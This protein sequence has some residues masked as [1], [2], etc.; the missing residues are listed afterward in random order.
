M[1]ERLRVFVGANELNYSE[2][3][4]T[5]S[6]D[7]QV[8]N[9]T[10][11]IEANS[12]VLDS[13]VI[14]F[15]KNDGLTSVMNA[16]VRSLTQEQLWKLECFT[17][18]YEL[19]NVWVQQVY[20]STSPEGIIADVVNNHTQNLTY[21]GTATSG[22]TLTG[23]I[24]DAY[25][26]DVIKDMLFIL[27]WQLRIDQN[28]NVYPEPQGTV[29]NGKTFTNG[30]NI[31]LSEW[32]SDQKQMFN[33]VRIRGGFESYGE[34][35]SLTGSSDTWVLAHKPSGSVKATVGGTV[36]D[37]SLYTVDAENK[38]I[39]FTSSRTD[40]VFDYS[41][42]R[43]IIVDDQNDSSISTYGEIFQKFEAPWLNSAYV[44]RKYAAGLLDAFSTPPV[45]AK[46][47]APNLDFITD[48]GEL[49]TLADPVRSKSNVQAVVNK[50]TL[51]P[52]QNITEYEF[53]PRD[54]L[55]SDW[56]ADVQNRIKQIERRISD[57][58]QIAFSRIFKHDMKVTLSLDY[59]WEYNTPGNS[60]VVGHP[61]L[62]V[63]RKDFDTEPDC[64]TNYNEGVWTGANVDG[65]GGQY[66]SSG[67]RLSCGEFNGSDTKVTVADDASMLNLWDGGGTIFM[68]INP[69]AA[70]GRTLAMKNRWKLWIDDEDTGTARIYFRIY[71]SGAYGEWRTSP[72]RPLT[73]GSWQSISVTYNSSDLTTPPVI[74]I[75]DV[76]QAIT[77]VNIPNG[78]RTTDSGYALRLGNY[79]TDYYDGLMDEV[80]M[81]DVA[82]DDD[83]LT[84][85]HNKIY[86]LNDCVLYFAFD[87]PV[88]GDHST[89]R[90][91]IT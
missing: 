64:S 12:N 49:V 23:Y 78:T 77:T 51:K 7:H 39:I 48:V 11:M 18:G 41:W 79:S 42:N 74:K 3:V 58:D 36:L 4:I 50:L 20:T 35:E 67:A 85:L 75:D 33:H 84:A 34:T 72:G 13:S 17:N 26:I 5:K 60:V 62:D 63:I 19:L 15:K 10:I 66:S 22:L 1:V 45:A 88:L 16:Q 70:D 87:N 59:T 24:A 25:A 69:D 71:T 90:T 30:S 40:P 53:G 91:T 83:I 21:A 31:S 43:P 52:H 38:S 46:G 81:Y 65:A 32:K 2:A 27:E 14:D 8:N 37:P 73:V 82:V 68:R 57:E 29:N 89:A 61:T 80:V 56:K 54:Y 9:A 28:D 44:A 6:N 76:A 47:T 55:L 86:Y